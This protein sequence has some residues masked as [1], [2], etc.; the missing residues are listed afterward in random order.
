[1]SSQGCRCPQCWTLCEFMQ[2]ETGRDYG[3][4]AAPGHHTQTVGPFEP[5]DPCAGTMTCDCKR[6]RLERQV[7]QNARARRVRQP[8]EP[9]RRAA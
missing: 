2:A 8:W 6:C 3:L 9:L 1:M 7:R 5:L 4:P